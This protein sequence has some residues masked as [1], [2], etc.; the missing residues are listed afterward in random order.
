MEE[1]IA[2]TVVVT[3][4]GAAEFTVDDLD[5][6]PDDGKRYELVDGTL[7]VSPSPRAGH[8]V[9]VLRLATLLDAAVGSRFSVVPAPFDWRLS[10]TTQFEPD[11]IVMPR[12]PHEALRLTQTPALVVEVL[13][14]STRRIDLGTKKLAY[15][16]AGVP[17]YWVF[18][19]WAPSMTIFRLGSSGQFDPPVEVG[20]RGRYVDP[21]FGV[22]VVPANVM[23]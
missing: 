11:V 22:E 4:L 1:P 6:M 21:T 3:T 23:A 13:S 5:S 19:P 15:E 12:L 7:I 8:Q 9:A 2:L 14:P 18:D 16:E 20:R 17:A 10:T